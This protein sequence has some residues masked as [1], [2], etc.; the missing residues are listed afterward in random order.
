MNP[1]F[2]TSD[3][4]GV[5][6]VTGANSGLGFATARIIASRSARSA[7]ILAC[8]NM[9]KGVEAER[10]ITEATGNTR[11]RAMRLDVSSMSSV[12]EFVAQWVTQP[13]PP[14]DAVICNAGIAGGSGPTADGFDPVFATN[15]LGHFLLTN[16]LL[17]SMSPTARVISVSSDMH[18]PPG[19]RLTWLGA[20]ALA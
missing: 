17:N 10:A 5:V 2:G 15:H 16:S 12:R 9:A 19:P 13:E 20:E 7:V 14:I 1:P 6:L 4:D 11:V 18:Q 3:C 8:R